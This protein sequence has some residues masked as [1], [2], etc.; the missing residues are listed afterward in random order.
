MNRRMHGR[1]VNANELTRLR[2]WL[3]WSALMD[4]I[5]SRDDFRHSTVEA[6]DLS[7][8]DRSGAL[9]RRRRPKSEDLTHLRG[10]M[11]VELTLY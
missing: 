8:P 9:P 5:E 10:P 6:R 2:L 1:I 7:R 3:T 4:L 11:L